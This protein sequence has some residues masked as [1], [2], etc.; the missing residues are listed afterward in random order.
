MQHCIPGG[1]GEIIVTIHDLKDT[2]CWFQP[3]PFHIS[4]LACAENR[5]ILENDSGLS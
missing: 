1:I 4:Y 3:L 2:E 5:W